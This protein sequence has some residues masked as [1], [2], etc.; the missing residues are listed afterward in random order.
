M[1][2]KKFASILCAAAVT[3]SAL[4]GCSTST[5]GDAATTAAPAADV[6]QAPAP[7]GGGETEA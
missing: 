3:M 2:L 1:K 5:G 7:D 4:A 6:S